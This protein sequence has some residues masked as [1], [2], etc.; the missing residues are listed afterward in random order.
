MANHV[1]RVFTSDDL[2]STTIQAEPYVTVWSGTDG[3]GGMPAYA[4]GTLSLYPGVR[5]RTDVGPE[6]E[7]GVIIYPLANVDTNTIDGKIQVPEPYPHTGS[8]RIFRCENI[9]QSSIDGVTASDERWYEEHHSTVRRLA[10][11]YHDNRKTTWAAE[12]SFPDVF[13]G[14][15]I[16]QM[17][18][19]RQIATGSITVEVN[20][21]IDTGEFSSTGTLYWRDDGLGRLWSVADASASWNTGVQVPATVLYN[22]G[23]I[24]FTHPSSDWHRVFMSGAGGMYEPHVKLTF[25][26]VQYIKSMVF[27]CRL[28]PGDANASNNPTYYITDGTGKRWAHDWA[29][30]NQATTYV[31]SIG[32]YNEER[33]L[34][35][36]AKIAQ[37]IRKREQDVIDIRL[38]LDI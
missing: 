22:E 14:I 10:Q 6:S 37:P 18:Y 19:G 25:R 17:F 15:H 2:F 29:K 7:S 30:S 5:S 28:G 20:S 34:V 21:F 8:I 26:S 1:Y 38:R 32:L 12:S 9:P 13:T 4:S 24:A 31:T 23:I 36:V 35:G 3:Y 27:M 33:Q 11:W 16:P